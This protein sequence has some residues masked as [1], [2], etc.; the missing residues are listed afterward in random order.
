M[1]V[2][3]GNLL[4]YLDKART[5][6]RCSH[7]VGSG[8][9]RAAAVASIGSRHRRLTLRAV[10]GSPAEECL[11]PGLCAAGFATAAGLTYRG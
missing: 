11:W 2:E 3:V 8:W 4:A 9:T 10:D 7:R 6:L 5:G 1:I